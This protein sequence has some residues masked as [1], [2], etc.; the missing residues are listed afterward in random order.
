MRQ[1]AA[2]C[3]RRWCGLAVDWVFPNFAWSGGS[4]RTLS[5]SEPVR[6]YIERLSVL[7]RLIWPSGC[8]LLPGHL[9]GVVDPHAPW[10]PWRPGVARQACH[11]STPQRHLRIGGGPIDG[12][13]LADAGI[14]DAMLTAKVANGD[15]GLLL[16]Q[17]R[18]D[19]LF[20]E[21]VRFISVLLMEQEPT[22]NW[23]RCR[24]QRENP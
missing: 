6:P 17:Y 3:S 22:S 16:F 20:G 10:L 9:D 13:P 24:G 18:N 4:I 19:L 7:R 8:P 5:S 1:S 23:I 21:P 15:A 14:A 11:G 2:L 12:L